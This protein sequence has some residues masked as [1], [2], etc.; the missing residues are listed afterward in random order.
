[1][2]LSLPSFTNRPPK[3]SYVPDRALLSSPLGSRA[4][5]HLQT[6]W[7]TFETKTALIATDFVDFPKNK[8]NFLHKNKQDTICSTDVG[9]ITES[10]HCAITG[11]CLCMRHRPSTR[12]LYRFGRLPDVYIICK[13]SEGSRQKDT[14]NPGSYLKGERPWSQPFWSLRAGNT[15]ILI[16]SPTH[17]PAL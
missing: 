9:K 7:C 6:T 14:S 17:I 12:R 10:V 5:P 2:T 8:C 15:S 16:H 13:Q 11:P 1:M 4:N 3:Y